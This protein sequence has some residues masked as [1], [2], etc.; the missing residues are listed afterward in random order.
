MC[1]FAGRWLVLDVC[2]VV[3]IVR[4][5]EDMERM[6]RELAMFS[7]ELGNERELFNVCEMEWT[8]VGFVLT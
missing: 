1:G 8:I 4:L 6:K 3:W 5:C 2:M 7:Q